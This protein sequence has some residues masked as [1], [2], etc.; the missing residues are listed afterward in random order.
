ML[1][2]LRTASSTTA[3][4]D[5]EGQESNPGVFRSLNHPATQSVVDTERV[6]NRLIERSAS[7]G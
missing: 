5:H 3:S 2:K 7:Q 4:Q 6:T 1:L